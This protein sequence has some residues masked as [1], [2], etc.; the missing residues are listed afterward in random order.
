MAK[1]RIAFRNLIYIYIVYDTLNNVVFHRYLN[2]NYQCKPSILE[3]YAIVLV[4]VGR[5]STNVTGSNV[6]L[7]I[8]IYVIYLLE[9]EVGVEVLLLT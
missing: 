7:R 5:Y 8:V 9:Y 1:G 4:V 3:Y 6:S 2:R